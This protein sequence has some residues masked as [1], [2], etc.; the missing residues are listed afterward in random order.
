MRDDEFH[1]R[2]M[3]AQEGACLLDIIDARAH[4]KTLAAAIAFAQQRFAHEHSSNGEMKVLT[5]SRS[6]GG[7]AM[8]ESSRTPVR[9]SCKR[10]RDRRRRQRQD[11]HLGAQFLQPLLVL[12]AEML[13]LVDN[14]EA[15]ILEVTLFAEHSVGADDDIDFAGGGAEPWRI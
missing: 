5:A 12:D 10:A 4:I 15:E 1:F 8:I 11:M 9:A 2:H 7:V 13:L 14:D 6:T 3:L